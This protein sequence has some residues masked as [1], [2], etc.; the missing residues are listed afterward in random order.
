[1]IIAIDPGSQKTGA[2]VVNADGTLV[3]KEIIPSSALEEWLAE[4]LEH[5]AID[6][7]V[8]GN[9]TRHQVMKKRAEKAV[10]RGGKPVPVVLVD[11]KYTTEMGEARYWEE[12]PPRGLARLIPRGMRTVPHPVDDYVAWIIGQIY[13]GIVRAEDVGHKKV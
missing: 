8:M 2:A 11:E 10:S 13:L 1:M 7:I 12:H 9:G 4:E 6:V 3:E 5:R